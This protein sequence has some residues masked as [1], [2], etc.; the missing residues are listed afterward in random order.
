[1]SNINF[2]KNKLTF[3]EKDKQKIFS[4]FIDPLNS[5]AER[6][7]V[8]KK[9]QIQADGNWFNLSFQS[10][11]IKKDRLVISAERVVN[12]ITPASYDPSEK[13]YVVEF[14]GTRAAYLRGYYKSR[15]PKGGWPFIWWDVR[16]YANHPNNS[17]V[18]VYVKDF[19]AH[20]EIRKLIVSM[21]RIYGTKN[22]VNAYIN[23]NLMR[24]QMGINTGKSPQQ[25]EV[26]WSKGMMEH[27]GY[28]HVEAFD[29]GLPVGKWRGVSVHWCKN[30]IDLRG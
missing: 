4:E 23:D 25:I 29:T 20:E 9:I 18:R 7:E 10:V 6:G 2:I 3:I 14:Q 30:A 24:F 26:N 27:L 28:K 12:G 13:Q 19:Y 11:E 5:M 17:N 22:I 15:H 8:N 21:E 16:S 1:M